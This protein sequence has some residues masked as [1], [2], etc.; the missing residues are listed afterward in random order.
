MVWMQ[1]RKDVRSLQNLV[2]QIGGYQPEPKF[3]I[4]FN[5]KLSIPKLT[6][7]ITGH[8]KKQDKTLRMDWQSI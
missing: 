3:T 1:P 4:Y 7:D 5:M 6:V 8:L 2:I